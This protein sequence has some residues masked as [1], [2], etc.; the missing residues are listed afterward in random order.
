MGNIFQVEGKL[1]RKTKIYETFLKKG[2][3]VG[4]MKVN[5]GKQ[6]WKGRIWTRFKKTTY[7]GL[8]GLD[9]IL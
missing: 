8:C 5:N 9:V 1:Q 4:L 7:C 6:S 2:R 3:V